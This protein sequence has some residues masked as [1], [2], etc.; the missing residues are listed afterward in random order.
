MKRILLISL[1]VTLLITSIAFAKPVDTLSDDT[2]ASKARVS[3]LMSSVNGIPHN[4]YIVGEHEKLLGSDWTWRQYNTYEEIWTGTYYA[5]LDKPGDSLAALQSVYLFSVRTYQNANPSWPAQRI[6]VYYPNYDGFYIVKGKAGQ[7]DILVC[8][9]RDTGG[10]SFTAKT[11]IIKNGK[12]QLLRF[13]NK[14]HKIN[15]SHNIGFDRLYYLDD[16]TL[17]VPWWTNDPVMHGR[18][19]TVY[20][21]D[22]D[23]LIL[24]SSYT[25]KIT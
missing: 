22:I 15:E 4:V 21:L 6:N 9:S 24:I 10:G 18:Y 2:A 20:M 19:T 16:G 13:M 14:E 11:F 8:T 7:P 5:Y 3:F 12:L 17:A 23:N 1:F 25:N